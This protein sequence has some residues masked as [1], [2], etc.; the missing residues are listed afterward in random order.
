MLQQFPNISQ[1]IADILAS[2]SYLQGEFVLVVGFL[3]LI[4][5]DLFL[6]K[7][8]LFGLLCTLFTLFLSGIF[9]VLD[10][11]ASAT[12]TLIFNGMLVASATVIKFKLLVLVITLISL[13]FFYQDHRLR[14]HPKGI[15]DF[16]SILLAMEIGLFLLI[17]S[18]NL[19][20]LYI[21]V[22]MISIAS[23]LMVA[24]NAYQKDQAEA[25]MKYVLFGT[26]ASAIMLYGI[27]LI[28][29]FTG[30]INLHG[31][32]MVQ[33]FEGVGFLASSISITMLLA[34]L[35]FKLSAVPFHFWTPDA[36]QVAPTSV[37]SFLSAAPKIAVFGLLYYIMPFFQEGD[38]FNQF[39]IAV[40]IASMLLGNIAALYQDNAKRM[41]SY[42]AIGHTGFMLML[43]VLPQGQILDV[44]FFY[45][46][47]YSVSNIAVFMAL[48]YIE[49]NYGYLQISQFKALGK[50]IPAIG[51][52]LVVLLMSLTGIPPMAGFVAKFLV[53]SAMVNAI[54]QSAVLWLLVVAVVTTVV[55]L[56]YYLKIPLNFFLKQSDANP[57]PAKSSALLA[58]L[59]IV[60]TVVVLLLGIFPGL[61]G[62][63]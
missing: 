21:G 61:L 24:Y 37:V 3:T 56:F 27:S 5:G 29:G 63:F 47:V 44:L 59:T 30:T 52:C 55:S 16:M 26:V 38:V 7:T 18:A 25:G 48:S 13:P 9:L 42:S 1:S 43:F 6:K 54:D 46:A 49:N 53:F 36:Y 10:L 32:A 39:I 28:Y 17:G 35:G 40:A 58:V 23:Y 33:G 57:L 19:L 8:R 62:G 11:Y 41:I 20:M 4:I 22:E 12:A 51:A 50:Q 2:L 34:G 45:L 15:N 31:G 14:Q 60:L